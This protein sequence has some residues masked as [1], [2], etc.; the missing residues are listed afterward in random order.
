MLDQLSI[1][2]NIRYSDCQP[3]HVGP[4]GKTFL[5]ELRFVPQT[6]LV[7]YISREKVPEKTER[8]ETQLLGYSLGSMHREEQ[9]GLRDRPNLAKEDTNRERR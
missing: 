6:C 9:N 8:I 7:I 5:G 2:V 3:L 1:L 4:D